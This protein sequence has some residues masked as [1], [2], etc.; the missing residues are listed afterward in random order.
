MSLGDEILSKSHQEAAP[1]M[2]R[3]MAVLRQRMEDVDLWAT[4]FEHSIQDSLDSM[5]NASDMTEELL[6]WLSSSEKALLS[7][8]EDPL[9][10]DPSLIE[11]MLIEHQVFTRAAHTLQSSSDRL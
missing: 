10:P 9:P 7:M 1:I 6:S 5:R 8:E 11:D 3:W 4:N 2:R